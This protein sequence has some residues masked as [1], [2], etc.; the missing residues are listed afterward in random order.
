M[1][2]VWTTHSIISNM[3]FG[4]IFSGELKA[5][6]RMSVQELGSEAQVSDDR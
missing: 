4:I 1:G 3:Y 6:Y 2:E 5:D